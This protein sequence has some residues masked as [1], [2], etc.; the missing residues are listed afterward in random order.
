MQAKQDLTGHIAARVCAAA[1][2]V[3]LGACAT[4]EEPVLPPPYP[5]T[6]GVGTAP[7]RQ[8]E[9]VVTDR[10][11][12]ESGLPAP[13]AAPAEAAP[14]VERALSLEAALDLAMNGH[15]ALKAAASELQARESEAVQAGLRPNP[16]IQTDV[17]NFGGAGS[18]SGL[19]GS[20]TTVTVGQLIELGG[21][22][23]RR[24]DAA[25]RETE[26]AGWDL[27]A[28]RLALYAEVTKLYVAAVAADK[29]RDVADRLF[30]VADRLQKAVAARVAA[31]KVSPIENQRAEI[32]VGRA[33][34]N[35][36]TANVERRA[37]F[38]SL[39]ATLGAPAVQIE[40]LTGVLG[41]I[42]PPPSLEAIAPYID[43]A[44]QIARWKTE[45][46]AREAAVRLE[47]ANRLP[48]VTVGAGARYFEESDS[49]A[50]VA[51]FSAPLPLFNRNQGAIGAARHRLE[52]SRSEAA[53]ARI[54]AERAFEGA[55]AALAASA[56]RAG[57]LERRLLPAA[58]RTFEATQIGY[59]EGKFDLVT[60][61]D[62]Q[63]TYFEIE[64]DAIDA[65][66]AYYAA[67]AD[68]EA[69]IGRDLSSISTAE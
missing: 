28:E 48:D 9:L 3:G 26:L 49:T 38:Q 59:R 54:D 37:A 69:L 8:S 51:S 60:L 11:R 32:V 17:E 10:G 42:A 30:A 33:D 46:A 50:L 6:S 66:A 64:T 21:K 62:A 44:P 13:E 55:Y 41:P 16:D 7:E 36:K 43:D 4:S 53:A 68:L 23:I 27:E 2:L 19:R 67:R 52:R 65:A 58:R 25:N 29:K 18:L 1:L 47:R 15:P 45:I 22:R 35:R 12:H 57:A 61:L 63:Q 40:K 5:L 39:A 24:I 14:P 31:G 20:E 56:A 34:V